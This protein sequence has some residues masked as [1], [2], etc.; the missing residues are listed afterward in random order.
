M[1]KKKKLLH[2]CG[3]VSF[4]RPRVYSVVVSLCSSVHSIVVLLCSRVYSIVVSDRLCVRVCIVSY[5]V[6]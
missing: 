5:S 4:L 3:V 1:C 2:M 6:F